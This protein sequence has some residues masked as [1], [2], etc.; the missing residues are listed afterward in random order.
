M[1]GGSQK[2]AVACRTLSLGALRYF[3]SRASLTA[4]SFF[5]EGGGGVVGGGGRV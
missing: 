5:W 4:F 3:R 1:G 2:V